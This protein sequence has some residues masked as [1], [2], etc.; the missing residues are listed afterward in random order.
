MSGPAEAS[1]EPPS[2]SWGE[3]SLPTGDLA[4][5]FPN[6]TAG[7]QHGFSFTL[8]FIKP[9]NGLQRNKAAVQERDSLSVQHIHIQGK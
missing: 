1:L 8:S 3:V 9:Y 2:Q 4:D 7:Q 6:N 5:P